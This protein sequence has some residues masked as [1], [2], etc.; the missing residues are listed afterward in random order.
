MLVACQTWDAL[1]TGILAD[2]EPLCGNAAA[3]VIVI[4]V[5]I[6]INKY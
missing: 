2:E 4:V 6:A 5:V 1:I 3:A